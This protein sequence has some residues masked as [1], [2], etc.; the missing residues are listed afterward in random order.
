MRG[1]IEYL[2]RGCGS[3]DGAGFARW[4]GLLIK[5]N[6][7]MTSYMQAPP[8]KESDGGR[9]VVWQT[10]HKYNCFIA[11]AGSQTVAYAFTDLQGLSF[12]RQC[13]LICFGAKL[14]DTR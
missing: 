1:S 12:A 6:V 3:G 2:D 5:S 7:D 10:R 8:C 13:H 4:D 14:S 11:S 9:P